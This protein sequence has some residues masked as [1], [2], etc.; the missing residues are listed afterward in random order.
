MNADGG[1]QNFL[2]QEWRCVHGDILRIRLG[3]RNCG[4]KRDGDR[5]K[6]GDP[7]RDRLI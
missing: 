7:S 6:R 4:F 5:K 3:P 1:A 2:E